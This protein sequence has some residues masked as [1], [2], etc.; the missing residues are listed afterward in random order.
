M[1]LTPLQWQQRNHQ[2]GQISGQLQLNRA[3]LF[4]V[5]ASDRLACLARLLSLLEIELRF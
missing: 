5:L 1:F 2:I 4:L 3:E